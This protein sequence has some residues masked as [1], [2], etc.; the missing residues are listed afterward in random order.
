[1]KDFR[2]IAT[3]YDKLARNTPR[4]RRSPPSLHSG[5]D[6]ERRFATSKTTMRGKPTMRRERAA[7]TDFTIPAHPAVEGIVTQVESARRAPANVRRME[8]ARHQML[9]G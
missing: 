3:R 6:S 4:F 1:M 7:F 9:L 2:K 8:H 5:I